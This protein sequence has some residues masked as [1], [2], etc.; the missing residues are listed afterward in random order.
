M[1]TRSTLQSITDNL[2]D[3]MGRRVNETVPQLS[4]VAKPKDVGRRA[5][6]SFGQIALTRVIPDPDQPRVEFDDNALEQLAQSIREQGQLHPIRVRWS[7]AHDSWLII[8]GERRY[9]AAKQAGLP[10]IQCYFHEG[11]LTKTEILEQQLIENL[12]RT[13]L[14]PIEEARAFRQLMQLND[15]TGKELAEAI[16][17]HASTITRALALLKLPED[18]QQLVESEKLAPTV[19]YELSKLS[20]SEKQRAAIQQHQTEPLT[21]SQVGRQVRQRRGVSNTRQRGVK[22]TFLTENGWKITATL[23]RKAN[24]HELEQ[25]LKQALDEVRLR[26]DNNVVLG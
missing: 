26:I 6:R 21:V 5:L 9:R 3:S 16:H 22:Q 20:S 1:S 17:V 14:R 25:A 15:W 10:T 7:D 8:S 12:L 4:P 2:D 11:D 23:G 24:Y 13:D 18:V 19:A